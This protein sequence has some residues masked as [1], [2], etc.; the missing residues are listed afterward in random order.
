MGYGV[1]NLAYYFYLQEGDCWEL[2]AVND[3]RPGARPTED[4]YHQQLVKKHGDTV[5]E[6]SIV[7]CSGANMVDVVFQNITFKD[8]PT[9]ELWFKGI[10]SLTNNVR[11]NNVCPK[12]NLQKQ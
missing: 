4:R 9:A 2:T 8:K 11:V 1:S 6:K 10:R 5:Y 7:V 3:V 12:T